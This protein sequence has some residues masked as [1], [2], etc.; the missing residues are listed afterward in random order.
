MGSDMPVSK[1]IVTTP[2]DAH[3]M[4]TII[5][6]DTIWGPIH[7]KAVYKLS[8]IAALVSIWPSPLPWKR[9]LVST[10]P[11]QSSDF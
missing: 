3:I 6:E 11:G 2:D 9:S 8:A 5:V 10:L 4:E 1:S 7:L